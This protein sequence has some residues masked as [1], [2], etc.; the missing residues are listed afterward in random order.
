MAKIGERVQTGVRIERRILKVLKGLAEHLDMSVKMVDAGEISYSRF[1]TDSH[2]SLKRRVQ[3][4]KDAGHNACLR[5]SPITKQPECFV[6]RKDEK[7]KT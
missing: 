6:K 2:K 3:Y 5:L 1:T 4:F 7:T